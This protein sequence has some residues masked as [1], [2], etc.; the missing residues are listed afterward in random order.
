MFDNARQFSLAIRGKFNRDVDLK[1]V[2]VIRS[3][4]RK[5]FKL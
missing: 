4:L 3:N 5:S 2:I 1:T